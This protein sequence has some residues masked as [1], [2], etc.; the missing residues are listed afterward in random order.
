MAS[1]APFRPR[2]RIDPAPGRLLVAEPALA[3][4]NFARTVVYLIDHDDDGTLGVVLNRPGTIDVGDVVPDW[5]PHATA[6]AVVFVGGPVRPEGAIC[7]ARR[8]PPD[9]RTSADTPAMFQPLTGNL[10]LIDLHQDPDEVVVDVDAVRVFGGYAGWS[11]GQ[12][13]AELAAGGWF[14]VE[15][16]DAD[17]FAADPGH[18][19]R[20]VLAR[21]HDVLRAVAQ[22][23]EDPIVN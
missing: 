15:S 4:P 1:D 10:G 21:Q 14:V 5:A 23:P 22:F 18:L 13:D 9:D 16:A 11:A 3:D 2:R 19:W 20:S 17:V 7:L 12:L 6:P 8:R